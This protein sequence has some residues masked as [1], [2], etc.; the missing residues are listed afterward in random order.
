M[1]NEERLIKNIGFIEIDVVYSLTRAM[2]QTPYRFEDGKR[3]LEEFAERFIK[4]LYT[5]DYENDELFNDLHS[6]FGTVCCL[7]E[8]QSALPGK[9]VTTKPLRLV[10]DRRPFI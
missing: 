8:L 5:V 2:R 9:V 7:C 10:L 3:A 6:L 1:D 4:Y